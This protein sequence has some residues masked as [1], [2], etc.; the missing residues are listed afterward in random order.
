MKAEAKRKERIG[1]VISAK[2]PKTI[3][4]K[5]ERRAPHT[6]M[7]KLVRSARKYHVHDEKGMAREGDVV[8]IV[9]CRPL[10]RLKRWRLTAVLTHASALTTPAE[11]SATAS[12][13]TV[14]N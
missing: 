1:V 11:A 13:A 2:T 7:G 12:D 10:S 14:H 4:V 3:V 6:V 8:R 5:I 9:E